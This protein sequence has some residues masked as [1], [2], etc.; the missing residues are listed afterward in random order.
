MRCAMHGTQ[1]P[2]DEEHPVCPVTICRTI[3]GTIEV[4]ICG[5]P[6]ED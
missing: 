5:L 6:L 3:A 4:G 1:E 2:Q